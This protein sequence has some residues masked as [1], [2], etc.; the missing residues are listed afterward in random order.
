M[1]AISF[2]TSGVVCIPARDFEGPVD[3]VLS[4]D[5]LS[6]FVQGY[7][8]ALFESLVE[9][10]HT[11]G[12]AF[13][14]LDPSALALILRDCEAWRCLYPRG[15]DDKQGGANMWLLRAEQMVERKDFPPLQPY[16]SDEG[17]VCLREEP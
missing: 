16:L 12:W 8:E 9:Q 11:T 10:T 17:R 13:R 15:R 7:V 1:E 3:R 5:K 4:W 6:P 2:D 14:Y